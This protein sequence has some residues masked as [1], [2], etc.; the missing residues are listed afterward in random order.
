MIL[1]NF[2]EIY[3]FRYWGF[4]FIKNSLTSGVFALLE[5]TW[6]T[7]SLLSKAILKHPVSIIMM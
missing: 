3:V 6:E 7:S 2:I 1:V 4:K 5:L